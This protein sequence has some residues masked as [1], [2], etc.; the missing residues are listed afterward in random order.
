MT[1]TK[2]PK[3]PT[4]AD[5]VGILELHLEALVEELRELKDKEAKRHRAECSHPASGLEYKDSSLYGATVSCKACGYSVFY[6]DSDVAKAA[7]EGAW[8]R[9]SLR[10]T[11]TKAYKPKP[12][13]WATVAFVLI[14]CLGPVF[15]VALV[16]QTVL[17]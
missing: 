12:I 5:R 3:Y 8:E 10:A 7:M 17:D 11:P 4:L 14:L 13:D 1:K 6:S 2:K 15:A 16:A 9:G